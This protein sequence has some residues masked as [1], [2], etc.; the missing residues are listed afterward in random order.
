M[1]QLIIRDDDMNYFTKVEDIKKV[2]N[3]LQGFPISFAIVPTVLDVSTVGACP[4]TKGNTTP[5]F[6]GDNAELVSWMKEEYKNGNVDILLHGITHSYTFPNGKRQFEMHWRDGE[7]N[8]TETLRQWREKLSALFGCDIKVFVAPGNRV[9]KY[10]LYSA[11][12]AGMDFSGLITPKFQRTF[13]IKNLGCYLKRW[14][15]RIWTGLQYPGV[16][17]YSDHKEI[18]A[19]PLREEEYLYKMF[20][21]CQKHDSPMAINVH[22][23]DLRDKPEQLA[24]LIKFVH[25]AIDNGAIPTKLSDVLK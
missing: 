13:T 18:N 23:W 19:C 15:M 25:Y 5:M 21:W 1:V 22:Y 4:D 7:E 24:K 20:N 6:V 3:K 9:T 10:T 2:Y 14:L 11:I 16:L 8:L 12:D 17:E